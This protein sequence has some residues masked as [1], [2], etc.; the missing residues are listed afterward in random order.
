MIHF[1]YYN[2]DIDKNNRF[3]L[4]NIMNI[5]KVLLL[6]FLILSVTAQQ[7]RGNND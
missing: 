5:F 7:L 2:F 1:K 6:V 4:F 3:L